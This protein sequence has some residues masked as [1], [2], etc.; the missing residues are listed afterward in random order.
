[1][2]AFQHMV[3]L[4]SFVLALAVAHQ[5]LSIVEIVRAGQRVSLS[6]VHAL[7]MVN[8]F[9]QVIGWWFGI[10]D[11]RDVKDWPFVSVMANFAAV[12]C[13]FLAIA[14]V[15]PRIPES[16]K[17]DLW[18]FHLQNRR[19]Y[20]L[21]IAVTNALAIA[22]SLYYG[23]AYGVPGQTLEAAFMALILLG[24]LAAMAFSSTSAQWLSAFASLGG[25]I[26]FFVVADPILK[27]G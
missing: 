11:L 12:V 15:C 8:A 19:R 2:S 7:W 16:G 25:T 6:A 17:F 23:S 9:L 3:T 27:S 5:L 20:A 4:L 13:V 22:V 24:A 18:K 21:F 10:W 26:L 14:F 1:M